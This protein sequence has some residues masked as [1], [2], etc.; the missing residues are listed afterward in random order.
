MSRLEALWEYQSA[1]IELE[2]L[3]RSMKNTETR[4]RLVRQQ[5]LF[6]NN[7]SHLKQ[8]EQESMLTQN[9]LVGITGQMD[10]LMAQI[11]EK[12][13][14]ILEIRDSDLE[15][16]FPEDVHEILKEC[17]SIRTSIETNKRKLVELMHE[18]EAAKKDIEETLIA[19]SR[20]K[21]AFDKLKAAHAKELEAGKGKLTEGRE[22]VQ[23]AA[24]Q[25]DEDLLAKYRRIKQHRSNPVAHLKNKRCQGC[26]M[27]VPSGVLQD[28]QKGDRIVTCENCGRILLVAEE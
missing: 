28:L 11:R 19:M 14:E 3:E 27:E 4:K 25:V 5:Q 12:D 22:K 24:L 15:D 10:K 13:V 8:I 20:A 2:V 18:I 7:Q 17:E 1:E 26:N 16:L 23:Q 9:S 21:K 6:K